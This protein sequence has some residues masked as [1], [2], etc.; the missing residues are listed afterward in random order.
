MSPKMFG[1]S[2][3]DARE[4]L[5]PDDG[6]VEH[7]VH[8][9][10][11]QAGVNS[12]SKGDV[13]FEWGQGVIQRVALV[14]DVAIAPSPGKQYDGGAILVDTLK[15]DAP[16]AIPAGVL[17]EIAAASKTV[18]SAPGKRRGYPEPTVRVVPRDLGQALLALVTDQ[19][20]PVLDALDGAEL[21]SDFLDKRA[22]HQLRARDDLYPEEKVEM[23]DSLYRRGGFRQAVEA[24]GQLCPFSGTD[25]P[26][27]MTIVLIKPWRDC[28]DAEKL[29]PENG[30]QL[31]K[32]LVDAFLL[33]AMSL[34]PTGHADISSQVDYEKTFMGTAMSADD[35]FPHTRLTPRQLKYF[36]FH[37]ANVFLGHGADRS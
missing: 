27:F 6:L 22:L 13:V 29:D 2:N 11:A 30:L 9:D 7:T 1:I 15:L 16:V 10:P 14:R 32:S 36:E 31:E 23:M 35:A 24:R 33:G 17:Q 34:Q 5:A 37:R 8:H 18:A 3:L 12:L 19:V 26:E 25:E 28:T 21:I 20:A 4:G